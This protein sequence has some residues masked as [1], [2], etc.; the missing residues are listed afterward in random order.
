MLEAWEIPGEQLVISLHLKP[1]E[2][3]FDFS[4]RMPRNA[5]RFMAMDAHA[6]ECESKRAKAKPPPSLFFHQCCHQKVLRTFTA[7]LPASNNL[8]MNVPHR[9]AQGLLLWLIPDLLKLKL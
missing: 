9:S 6:S 7:R 2:T 4:D 8:I 1:G 3:E 5:T